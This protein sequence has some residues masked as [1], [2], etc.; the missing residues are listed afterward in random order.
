MSLPLIRRSKPKHRAADKV[1]ELE[2]QLKDQQAETV[3]AFGQLIGAA[4]TIAILE[5]DLA[6]VRAKRAEAEEV[7][8]CLDADLRD[9]TAELEQARADLAAAQAQ[10]APYLAAEANANAVTVPPSE[11]DISSFE[12]QATAPI[13]VTTLWDALGIGP[14]VR[15][16]GSTDPAHLPAA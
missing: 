3:S 14:V 13:K 12:D 9:R 10:L 16:E 2:R 11:R 7:V 6:D 5:A 15:T 4:D 8:V 1:A